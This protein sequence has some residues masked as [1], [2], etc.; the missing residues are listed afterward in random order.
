[1][2][3]LSATLD[4]IH[5]NTVAILGVP[6]DENSSFLRGA[7][8]APDHIRQVL[9]DGASNMY[10]EAGTDL[11]TQS[12]LVDI[13]NLNLST[14]QAFQKIHLSI[15]KGLENGGRFLCLGGDHAVTYPILLAYTQH[16]EPINILHIDAHPD[17]YDEFEGNRL[18]HA[19]PF[20]RIM[21]TGKIGRLVQIGIRSQNAHLRQ[22]IERFQ[23]ESYAVQGW[24]P[25][26]V[27]SL[28][29]PLYLSLDLD[30]L[31]PAFAPGVSH[32]EPGGLTSREVLSI[33]QAIQAP[34]VGADIV[35]LN[36]TRDLNQ[37]TTRLAAKFLREIA[38]KM[39]TQEF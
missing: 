31:D 35:E 6:W 14:D 1:M 28:S 39:L 10:N 8:L 13:G 25:E 36:P 18:S 34:L 9:N 15:A 37:V 29:G 23:V 24:S 27:A 20:A 4:Q 38:A 11:E 3:I 2:P 26:L 5:Q 30:G 32:H 33:I 7:A 21:E 22:Q 19:C 12:N 17:L 16:H